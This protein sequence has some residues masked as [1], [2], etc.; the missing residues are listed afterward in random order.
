VLI[1]KGSVIN[2]AGQIGGFTSRV[3]RGATSLRHWQVNGS[4][5]YATD[6]F[7]VTAQGRYLQGCKADKMLL[8]P[9]DADNN[10]AAPIDCRSAVVR[11]G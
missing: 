7:S 8:D 2:R 4:L 9:S 11:R 3:N 6:L 5:T 1:T 10:P